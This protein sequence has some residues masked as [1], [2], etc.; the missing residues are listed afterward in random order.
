MSARSSDCSAAAPKKVG[1]VQSS[2]LSIVTSATSPARVTL[3]SVTGAKV[4]PQER[5][6][7]AHTDAERSQPVVHM[8]PLLEP[9]RELRHQSHARGRERMTAGDRTAVRIEAL[10]FGIDA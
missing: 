1:F 2:P 10:V 5:R 3:N 8:R 9:V 7:H 6:T 4:L